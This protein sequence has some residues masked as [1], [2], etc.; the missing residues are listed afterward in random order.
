M[1]VGVFFSETIKGREGVKLQC[2]VVFSIQVFH[3]LMS[4][5]IVNKSQYFNNQT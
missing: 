3:S 5:P 1:R 2:N 4:V